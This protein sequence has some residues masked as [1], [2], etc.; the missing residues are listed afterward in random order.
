MDKQDQSSSR[1]QISQA[2]AFQTETLPTANMAH[3]DAVGRG[4]HSIAYAPSVDPRGPVALPAYRGIARRR[5]EP[6]APGHEQDCERGFG[7]ARPGADRGGERRV[8][9]PGLSRRHGSSPA[10]R[11]LGC[12]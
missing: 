10:E 4:V 12:G 3:R 9:T 8:V 11:A 1:F 2:F 7:P 5:G 6:V